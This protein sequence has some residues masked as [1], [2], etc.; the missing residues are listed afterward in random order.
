MYHTDKRR[1]PMTAQTDKPAP[2]NV[3]KPKPEPEDEKEK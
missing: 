1:F 3:P 2:V